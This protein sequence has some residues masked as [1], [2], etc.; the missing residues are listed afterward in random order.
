M[1]SL[2]LSNQAWNLEGLDQPVIAGT[3]APTGVIGSIIIIQDGT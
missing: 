2:A 3:N 1:P